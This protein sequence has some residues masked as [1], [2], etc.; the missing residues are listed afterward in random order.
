MTENKDSIKQQLQ[1]KFEDFQVVPPDDGW[2]RIE[3][4]LFAAQKATLFTRWRRVGIAAALAAL[5]VG[6]ILIM[7]HPE[8][9]SSKQ[10][11][12][13]NDLTTSS[14]TTNQSTLEET[15]SVFNSK[16]TEYEKSLLNKN[17]ESHRTLIAKEKSAK[18]SYILLAEADPNL[19]KESYQHKTQSDDNN[20][21][22]EGN[23]VSHSLSNEKNEEENFSKEDRERLIR[24]FAVAA[25][26]NGI[27]TEFPSQQSE[28]GLQL[29]MAGRS[30]F[31]AFQKT[32]NAPIS[33]RSAAVIVDKETKE[34]LK[35]LNALSS[36]NEVTEVKTNIAEMEHAQ[37]ISFGLTVSKEIFDN[38]YLETGLVYTYLYSKAKNINPD[39]KNAET[40][41]FH[42][43]GVP[44]NINYRLAR[45]SNVDIYCSLGGMVEKDVY[46]EF[47]TEQHLD[48][49]KVSE[50]SK[51]MSSMH[52]RQK[53]PQFSVNAGIGASYPIYGKM[54]LYGKIGGAYYFDAQNDYKTIYS[55]RKIMLD[56]N[57]GLRIGF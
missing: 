5:I 50:A 32:V 41:H 38:F 11:F 2:E 13:D 22:Q 4:S 43:L 23:N 35:T 45:F 20:S 26:K 6:G 3:N 15:P 42:Y 48:A 44:L 25:E 12:A 21:Q 33:L 9:P 7:H 29:A 1:A 49:N 36:T 53:R 39:Y 30:G 54:K 57:L 31:N 34:E 52:I 14:E 17:I 19:V 37:P 24:E 18:T 47:R 16:Q 10:L 8:E 27:D 40:Q 28:K 56:L 51:K 55:D 46:G